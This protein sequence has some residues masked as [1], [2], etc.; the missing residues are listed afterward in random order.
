M[1]PISVLLVTGRGNLAPDHP[2][3]GWVHDFYPGAIEDAFGKEARVNA[4]GDTR[5]LSR[6]SLRDF[7][8]VVNNSLFM[9]PSSEQFEALLSFVEHGGGFVALHTGL[10]SFLNDARYEG[11]LGAR[12]IGHAP[13]KAFQVDPTDVWYGWVQA[14]APRHPISDRMATFGTVDELYVEQ[15]NTADVTVVARAELL[16]VMWAREL[17]AG[18]VVCLALGHDETAIA[19]PG[20]RHLLLNGVRWAAKR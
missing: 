20:F 13:I 18:R 17:G 12:F 7:E 19:V 11:M 15:M 9:E 3:P 4:V 5:S 14:G 16:P 6:D 1:N 10:V 2:Y 8:V